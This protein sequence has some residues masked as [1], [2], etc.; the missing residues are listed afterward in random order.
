MP[1]GDRFGPHPKDKEV[2]AALYRDR[3]PATRQSLAKKLCHVRDGSMVRG[4]Q[5][6]HCG[7]NREKK[8]NPAAQKAG[9]AGGYAY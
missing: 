4:G 6:V 1:C 5:E 9:T 3:G 7:T 8:H 2:A